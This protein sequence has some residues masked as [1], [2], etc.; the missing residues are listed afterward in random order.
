[1]L[2]LFDIMWTASYPALLASRRNPECSL[3][4]YNRVVDAS[5]LTQAEVRR[6]PSDVQ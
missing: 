4:A 3:Y 1:M 6:D 2:G 5:M